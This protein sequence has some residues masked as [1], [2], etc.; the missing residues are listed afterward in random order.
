MNKWWNQSWKWADALSGAVVALL[1]LIALLAPG[2]LLGFLSLTVGAAIL[3]FG[4]V[5]IFRSVR[6]YKAVGALPMPMFLTGVIAAVIGLIFLINR[7]APISIFATV[8]GIWALCSGAVKLNRAIAA[9]QAAASCTWLF[10]QSF[11]NIA[12]GFFLVVNP[13]GGTKLWVS[14]IGAYLVYLGVVF[15]IGALTAKETP[16]R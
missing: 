2:F 12:F 3:I 10:I 9:R 8:F 13:W 14:V 7:S 6:S 1:G 5:Q 11:I 4:G 15:T 16:M